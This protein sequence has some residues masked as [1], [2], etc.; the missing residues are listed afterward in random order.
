M[1]TQVRVAGTD[2]VAGGADPGRSPGTSGTA[3][4]RSMAAAAVNVRQLDAETIRTV[5]GTCSPATD[6]R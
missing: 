4:G 2:A 6:R 1:L 3:N 5:A